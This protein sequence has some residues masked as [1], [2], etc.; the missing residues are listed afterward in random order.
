[1]N[2]FLYNPRSNNDNNDLSIVPDAGAEN[3]D[4]A[5]KICLLDLDVKAFVSGLTPRDRVYICGGDGTLHHFANNSWGVDFPCPVYVIRSGTGNDFLNDIGQQ[6]NFELVDVRK[7]LAELPE[8]EMNGKRRR[9]LN[10]VGFGL[11]GEVCLGVENFKKNHPGKKAS[12]AAIAVK[13]LLLTYQ[14]PNARVTVDGVTKLYRDVW[15]VSTMKGKYYGGGLKV[16]PGQERS[17]GKLSVIVMH[18]GSRVKALSLFAVLGK[19]EHV[20]NKQIVEVIEGYD[21]KVE[22]DQPSVLQIDGEVYLN[23]SRYRANVKEIAAAP[24]KSKEQKAA[25]TI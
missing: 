16:A 7:Y 11:D 20:K 14:R 15:A 1:M 3:R 12:Y 10:G 13:L 4:V 21:V 22:F 9:F 8:A 6:D 23:V 18:G 24:Q 2:Y 17:G 5:R 25:Q 19:G